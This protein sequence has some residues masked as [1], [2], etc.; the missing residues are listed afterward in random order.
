MNEELRDI[1]LPPDIAW[2]PP[3]VGWWVLMIVALLTLVGVFYYLSRARAPVRRVQGTLPSA[4]AELDRIEHAYRHDPRALVCE[5]S[6]LLRRVAISLYGRQAVAGL[7]GDHWL[8]VLDRQQ[9]SPVF[10]KKF[11]QALTELPYQP[12]GE[13]DTKALIEEIR[14]WLQLQAH[15]QVQQANAPTQGAH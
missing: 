14:S 6:V 5:L 12:S 3:A 9:P 7:T 11:R 4:V 1:R 15:L 10:T 2:W 8:Q 13:T